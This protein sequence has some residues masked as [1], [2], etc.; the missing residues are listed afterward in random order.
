MFPSDDKHQMNMQCGWHKKCMGFIS[1]PW[2]TFK[3]SLRTAQSTNCHCR[4]N[5]RCLF[6]HPY[7]IHKYN[8]WTW[9]RIFKC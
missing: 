9:C 8:V 1:K 2:I 4:K 3:Y 7:K 5:N 6:R